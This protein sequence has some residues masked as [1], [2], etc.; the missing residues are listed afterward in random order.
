MHGYHTP[1]GFYY[2]RDEEPPA[3]EEKPPGCLDT[4]LVTRAV[5]AVLL[6]IVG[7]LIIVFVDIAL[8]LYLFARHPALALIPVAVT[9][10]A[11]WAYAQWE[12]R[13]FRPPGT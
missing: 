6:P 2:G 4:L 3:Q 10:L 5:F 7:V 11:I 1:V 9:A 8:V 12:Q 13:K